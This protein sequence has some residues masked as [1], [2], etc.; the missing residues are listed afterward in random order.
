MYIIILFLLFILTRFAARGLFDRKW[1]HKAQDIIDSI[2]NEKNFWYLM[3]QDINVK[4]VFS[5]Y[6]RILNQRDYIRV[7]DSIMNLYGEHEADPNDLDKKIIT[8]NRGIEI[9]NSILNPAIQDREKA[10][11]EYLT[12]NKIHFSESEIREVF[13]DFETWNDKELLNSLPRN[14]GRYIYNHIDSLIKGEKT[15]LIVWEMLK[16]LE[17][18]THDFEYDSSGEN[19]VNFIS[20]LKM[21]QAQVSNTFIELLSKKIEQ[22]EIV[23]KIAEWQQF[24]MLRWCVVDWSVWNIGTNGIQRGMWRLVNSLFL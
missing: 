15:A 2:R 4:R 12:N 1:K 19:K 23:K 3:S 21:A 9:I 8:K 22:K 20:D 14:Y 13:E 7:G 18:K 10:I 6:V 5:V 11:S 16:E 24:H 17:D